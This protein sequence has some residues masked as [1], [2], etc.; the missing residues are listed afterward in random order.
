MVRFDDLIDQ[1]VCARGPGA[2]LIERYLGRNLHSRALSRRRGRQLARPNGEGS[3]L[4]RFG[5]SNR[6]QWR[7]RAVLMKGSIE[8]KLNGFHRGCI[9]A[10]II[11]ARRILSNH[12]C[13][14]YRRRGHVAHE[15][16]EPKR[17][18]SHRGVSLVALVPDA[19]GISGP[20]GW[21]DGANSAFVY[22]VIA[23]SVPNPRLSGIEERRPRLTPPI[24][25]PVV[26]T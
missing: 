23:E 22:G 21:C 25:C 7:R 11:E 9:K 4:R 12:R 18:R 15:N 14:Y 1:A 20:R 16:T 3:R 24:Y 26:S 2:S 13:R 8:S 17:T 10:R 6:G 5:Y 19:S